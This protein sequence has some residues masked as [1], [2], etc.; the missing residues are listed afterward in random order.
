M[1]VST[2]YVVEKF[3]GQ[4][5]TGGLAEDQVVGTA[6]VRVSEM[7]AQLSIDGFRPTEIQAVDRTLIRLSFLCKLMTSMFQLLKQD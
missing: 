7:K 6:G 4:M 3:C 5:R 1:T 2:M